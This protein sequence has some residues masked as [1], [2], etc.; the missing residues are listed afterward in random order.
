MQNAKVLILDDEKNITTV[1]QAILGKVGITSDTFQDPHAALHAIHQEE[2][3]TLITDLF[4]P[5]MDGMEV[6]S[7]MQRDHKHIPVVMIT[8]FG[9]IGSAVNALK[10]GAFD[11]ITKPFEPPVLLAKIKELL[12]KST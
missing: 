3:G 5:S 8:A 9:T 1:I 7:Q 6:L 10:L 2:Y 11:Y 12:E 4:M